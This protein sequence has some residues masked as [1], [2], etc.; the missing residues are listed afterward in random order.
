MVK[1]KFFY[2]L[3]HQNSETIGIR[4]KGQGDDTK[5]LSLTSYVLDSL[6]CLYFPGFSMGQKCVIYRKD[7]VPRTSAF[8]GNNYTVCRNS[9][10]HLRLTFIK[11]TPSSHSISSLKALRMTGYVPKSTEKYKHLTEM[12]LAKSQHCSASL[13]VCHKRGLDPERTDVLFCF[14]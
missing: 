7:K 9:S 12:V 10:Q 5:I 2:K 14:L 3:H 4:S 11:P 1:V 8:L 13:V 6:D